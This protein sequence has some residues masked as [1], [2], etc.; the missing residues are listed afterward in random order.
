[1][2]YYYECCGRRVPLCRVTSE[3][4]KHTMIPS[5]AKIVEEFDSNHHEYHLDYEWE[6]SC[7]DCAECLHSPDDSVLWSIR[8]LF[9]E[10]PIEIGWG[11]QE[12][13]K[14]IGAGL[15]KNSTVAWLNRRWGDDF[16]I[17]Y[18]WGF[19]IRRYTNFDGFEEVD[20]DEVDYDEC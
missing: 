3:D 11:A 17:Q 13:E 18:H 16:Q 1:M 8:F 20:L 4:G 7:P 14:R 9:D 19:D 2:I 6:S 10:D 12:C 15:L 5:T